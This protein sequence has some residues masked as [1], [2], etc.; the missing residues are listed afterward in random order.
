VIKPKWHPDFDLENVPDVPMAELPFK[1]KISHLEE[2]SRQKNAQ[3][4]VI[5]PERSI[6][7]ATKGDSSNTTGSTADNVES[8]GENGS[9]PSKPMSRAAALLERVL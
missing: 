6:S 7:D 9:A 5:S 4:T 2:W 1:A 3:E 8:N